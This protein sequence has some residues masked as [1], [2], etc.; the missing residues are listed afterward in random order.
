MSAD[1]DIVDNVPKTLL[2]PK[3]GRCHVFIQ[4]AAAHILVH[5]IVHHICYGGHERKKHYV[6]KDSLD[7]HYNHGLQI[8]KNRIWKKTCE[9]DDN[10]VKTIVILTE[11]E[12]LKIKH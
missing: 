4:S 12:G 9:V 3:Y 10:D 7:G 5:S 2:P 8:N 6:D 1:K 11:H